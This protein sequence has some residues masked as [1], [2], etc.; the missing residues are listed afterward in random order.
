LY[1]AAEF[2]PKEKEAAIRV[3][4]DISG[5]FADETEVNRNEDSAGLDGGEIGLNKGD[6]VVKEDGDLVAFFQP[7]TK[8]PMGQ[9]IHPEVEGPVGKSLLAADQGGVFRI[10]APRASEFA[11]IHASEFNPRIKRRGLHRH[12]DAVGS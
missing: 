7:E 10:C 12:P 5:L 6:G 2:I 3:V 9:L 4:E 1:K 11:H 8:K